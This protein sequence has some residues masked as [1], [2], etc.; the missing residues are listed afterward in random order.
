[1]VSESEGP[2]TLLDMARNIGVPTGLVYDNSKVMAGK[3]WKKYM[4]QFWIKEIGH[5]EA[6]KPWQNP[7]E[8]EWSHLVPIYKKAWIL[9][10]CPKE[11]WFCL[12]RHVLDIAEHTA[13]KS[14]GW[15][16]PY[17]VSTGETD[18]ISFLLRFLFWQLVLFFDPSA[19]IPMEGGNERLGRW[20]GRA[21][22][23]GDGMCY[24]IYTDDTQE[25]IVRSGVRCATEGKINA[26]Y[27]DRIEQLLKEDDTRMKQHVDPTV[28]YEK[29]ERV[30]DA[31]GTI[32]VK[33]APLVIPKEKLL[34]MFV[35]DTITTK[36]GLEKEKKGYV[37]EVLGDDAVRVQFPGGKQKVYEYEEF[38]NKVNEPE[39][40][41]GELWQFSNII[42][43]RYSKAEPNKIELL[44][45]WVGYEPSWVPWKDIRHTDPVSLAE[46]AQKNDLLEKSRWKWAKRYVKNA[47]TFK[48]ML[49]QV[50]LMKKRTKQAMKWKFGV[51][52]PRS[53]AEAKKFDKEN[54]N[55]AW[56][57]AV[58][59]EVILLRD[60]Y[61]CFRV[62]EDPSEITDEY[63]HV[64]LLWAFDCKF[65]GRLRARCV[66]GGHTTEDPH[67]AYYSG[68][69][70]LE[71][72]RILLLIAVLVDLQVV[73]GDVASAYLESLTIELLCCVLGEEFGHMAGL[74]VII[75][76]AVYGA[77]LSSH[78]WHSKL[79]DSLIHMGFVPSKAALD[80]WMR[81]RVDH[82][83]YVAVIVDD[84]LVFSKKPEQI[85]GPLTD[86]Y[87]FGL[88]GVGTPEYYSG[89]D[90]LYNATT[91]FWEVSAKTYIKRCKE[92]I[93]AM[94]DIQLKN[95][96][97][98]MEG[99]DH[100][101][102]DETPLM[103]AEEITKY[104]MLVGMG[105]W[106]VTLGRFDVQYAVNTMARY[107]A[108][109]KK[110][111]F[112]RMF[113]IFGYLAFHDK[114]RI[115]FDPS[116]PNW[117]DFEYVD[118]DWGHMYPDSVE[119]IDPNTPEPLVPELKQT[120][121]A[122]SSH[123][124]DFV[125]RKSTGSYWIFLG[126]TVVAAYSKRLATVE[127]A[128]YGA[129]LVMGR[130]A[131]EAT[132]AMRYKLRMLGVKVESP[133]LIL[134]DNQSVVCNLQ[135]PS[136]A[137]KKK[138]HACNY[139]R[140]REIISAHIARVAFVRSKFNIADVGTKPLGPHAHYMLLKEVF[141]GRYMF[142]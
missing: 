6:H 63:Q 68:V 24:W 83:E 117:D 11:A 118:S 50:K 94:F 43:H 55:T 107:S 74:L 54:G 86:V 18:D 15:R 34:D 22:G 75:A 106:A 20:C 97:S 25:L 142:D 90:I 16:T 58:Q 87:G 135:L 38:I 49:K 112:L 89:A 85:L 114:A 73:A 69:A 41:D 7:F 79:A 133:A 124:N 52:I 42:G 19:K 104:Q 28:Y 47:K 70:S 101:E 81:K 37:K 139:H 40:F 33:N 66:C 138:H 109:P 132:V 110:G 102:L 26:Y 29:G 125:T 141:Y 105:Q 60:T 95:Y 108:A 1:M 2:N 134:C 8:R 120:T 131:L 48:R 30:P 4:R 128:T 9:T 44:I 136:S 3:L 12:L 80:I 129:E 57:D 78:M 77:K 51:K 121:V 13:R 14:L 35:Y 123:A 126:C 103:I 130:I 27:K 99:D 88:K 115:S 71:D 45:D 46:Y 10:G 39:D 119:Y 140:A 111:H 31:D 91:G 5:N 113:R 137:L 122:D 21:K 23:Y 61:E 116:D 76:K 62:P 93:E 127:A 98:P 36:T 56:M 32:A 67:W 59:T 96:G 65:D 72:V 53:L 17:E 82:Y 92:R 100:P 64:T 84:L